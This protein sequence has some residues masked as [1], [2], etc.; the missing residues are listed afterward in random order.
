CLDLT[1]RPPTSTLFP[2]TTLFRSQLKLPR[3]RQLQRHHPHRQSRLSLLRPVPAGRRN[4]RQSRGSIRKIVANPLLPPIHPGQYQGPSPAPAR[5]PPPPLHRQADSPQLHL[6]PRL[7]K[8]RRALLV[9]LPQTRRH[10][11]LRMNP[12]EIPLK[13]PSSVTDL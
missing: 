6:R 3:Q 2:Y 8:S 12:T 5:R 9:R 4:R 1:P 13:S 7:N 10:D 11:F